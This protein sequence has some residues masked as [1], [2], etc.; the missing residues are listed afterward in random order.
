[1]QDNREEGIM[2]PTLGSYLLNLQEQERY[3]PAEA[4]REVPTVEELARAAGVSKQALY[5]LINGKTQSIRFDV[6]GAIIQT[7][8][9]RGFETQITDILSYRRVPIPGSPARV[10]QGSG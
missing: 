6:A 1:M 9:D 7:F 8:E 2:Y 4:R 3:K 10:E 5:D